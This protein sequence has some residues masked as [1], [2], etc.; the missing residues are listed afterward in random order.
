MTPMTNRIV[1]VDL[2]D[3]ILE[4]A[5]A[6]VWV[7]VQVER[8]TPTTE[9]R[10]RLM[11][12]TCPY[13]STVE[14]SYPLRPPAKGQAAPAF[15]YTTLAMRVV[16]PEPSMWDPQCPFLYHGPVELWQDGKR[17]DRTKV[18]HGCYSMTLDAHGMKWNGRPLPLQSREVEALS[19]EEMRVLHDAGVNLLI[20]SIGDKTAPLWDHADRL[21][22]LMLGR[23]TAL[24][25]PLLQEL[26]QHPSS[27][28]FLV[29]AATWVLD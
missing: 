1:R 13:A 25:D 20:A 7:V 23:V 12:P 17:C 5:V 22:F 27:V 24:D 29:D 8:V 21:G 28:G 9:V 10:G 19:E 4:P 11:G 26:G 3:H 2:F 18:R 6:E 15:G 14:V 16:I